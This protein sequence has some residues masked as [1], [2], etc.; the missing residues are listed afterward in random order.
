MRAAEFIFE[1]QFHPWQEKAMAGMK[2][3]PNTDQYHEIYRFGVAMAGAGRREDPHLGDKEGPVRD[4]P[5]VMGYS[6]ADDKIINDT[7]AFIGVSSTQITTS[8][9]EE[10]SDTYTISPMCPRGPIKRRS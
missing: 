1:G 4:N 10:P 7:L 5:A 8:K 2:A 3:L 6:H 9:S